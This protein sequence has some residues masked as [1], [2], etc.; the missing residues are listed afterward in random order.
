VERE[1][2]LLLEEDFVIPV[3]KKFLRPV[4]VLFLMT[5]YG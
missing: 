4:G 5:V 1:L 2:R 3:L